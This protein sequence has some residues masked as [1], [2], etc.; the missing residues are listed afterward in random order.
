MWSNNIHTSVSIPFIYLPALVKFWT[1]GR[2]ICVT[3]I[4]ALHCNTFSKKKKP[5]KKGGVVAGLPEQLS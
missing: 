3:L 2:E 5:T 4:Y 1:Q